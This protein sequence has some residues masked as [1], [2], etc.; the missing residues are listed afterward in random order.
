[1]GTVATLAVNVIAR[2]GDFNKGL[3]K[4]GTKAKGFGKSVGS[5]SGGATGGLMKFVPALALATTAAAVA[6]VAY[7]ELGAAF[8]RIDEMAKKASRLGITSQSL[9]ALSYSAEL[10]GASADVM[11]DVL[12]TLQK[13]MGDAAMGTGEAAASLKVL[14]L[15]VDKLA[16][17]DADEQFKTISEAI[18]KIENP[19]LQAALAAKIF[20]EGSQQVMDV[21]RGGNDALEE[22]E[23]RLKHLQGT[24]DKTD[25]TAVAD[26]HDAWTDVQKAIEG[27]WEQLSVLLAPALEMIGNILAEVIAWVTRS[28]EWFRRLG[29]EW[30]GLILLGSPLLGIIKMLGGANDKQTEAVKKLTAAEK[31]QAVEAL[32]TAEAEQKAIE[33]TAKARE[34]LEKKGAKLTESL[35]SPLEKYNDTVG[36]LNTMLDAGV[37]S[38]DTYG[39]AVAK[40]QDDIKKSDEFKAKEIKVAER[41]AVGVSLRGRG[42]FSI[43]QKQQRTLEK[44]REEERQQLKQLK[45]QTTLLQQLNNN[46]QTGTVVTI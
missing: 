16:G 8:A 29:D 15:D 5:A 18:S 32:K 7:R 13:N 12:K 2:T 6:T 21:I 39:R 20:G 31:L 24:I 30:N 35:R 41:Q 17:M 23:Q 19:A 43:Q 22:N 36:E 46:V 26:M 34:A 45:Q 9:K 3:D 38:W 40:A 37:I 28:V 27:L 14:G 1:M 10:A 44:L 25:E 33:E 11:N 42:A 4:A